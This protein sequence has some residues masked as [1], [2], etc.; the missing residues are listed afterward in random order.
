MSSSLSSVDL[1][2]LLTNTVYLIIPQPIIALSQ[3]F[4]PVILSATKS[5]CLDKMA[6]VARLFMSLSF[7]R[8]SIK[9]PL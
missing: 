2:R 1:A 3:S 4:V 9:S 8:P 6:P 7:L 5:R